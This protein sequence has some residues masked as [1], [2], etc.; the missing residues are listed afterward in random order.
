MLHPPP[1]CL[2]PTN[3]VYL[4]VTF[5]ILCGDLKT[6]KPDA[7]PQG[8]AGVLACQSMRVGSWTE[9]QPESKASTAH[10][11]ACGQSVLRTSLL[12]SVSLFISILCTVRESYSGEGVCPMGES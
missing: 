7:C 4:I 5:R 6:R 9:T 8:L 12:L 3:C 2:C 11:A 1:V 10:A